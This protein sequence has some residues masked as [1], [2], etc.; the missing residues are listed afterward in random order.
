MIEPQRDAA[1]ASR[2]D[3]ALGDQQ[4]CG[5]QISRFEDRDVRS[6]IRLAA[7]REAL[8]RGEDPDAVID[9]EYRAAYAFRESD[10][11]VL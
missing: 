3:A 1:V 11:A 4:D 6:A 10:A 2:R 5:P 7:V 8:L 9:R